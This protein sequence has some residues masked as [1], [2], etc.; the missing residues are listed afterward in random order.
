MKPWIVT[1]AYYFP[2]ETMREEK[3][4]G[5]RDLG[6]FACLVITALVLYFWIWIAI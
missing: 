4:N 1:G 5:E 2:G 3:N 6:I